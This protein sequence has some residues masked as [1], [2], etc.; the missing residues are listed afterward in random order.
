[1]IKGIENFDS[2][3]Q[4]AILSCIVEQFDLSEDIEVEEVDEHVIS[5][6]DIRFFVIPNSETYKLVA[7]HN[8]EEFDKY[9]DNL[10]Q[11]QLRYIDEDLWDEDYGIHTFE[12]WLKEHTDYSVD[13]CEYYEDFRFYEIH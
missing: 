7:S 12:E 13:S 11:D 4:K 8:S 1:M 2:K 6:G 5:I 3:L 9:F 10:S